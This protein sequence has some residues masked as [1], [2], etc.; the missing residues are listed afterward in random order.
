M[1]QTYEKYLTFNI[2]G[3]YYSW[4]RK[5]FESLLGDE[6]IS[7]VWDKAEDSKIDLNEFKF[8]SGEKI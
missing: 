2:E 5:Y 3:N 8:L 1:K 4:A 6:T 7:A